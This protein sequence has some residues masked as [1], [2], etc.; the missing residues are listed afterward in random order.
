MEQVAPDFMASNYTIK[1]NGDRGVLERRET[2]IAETTMDA[3]SWNCY[4]TIKIY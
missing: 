2:L 3:S 1:F 4:V